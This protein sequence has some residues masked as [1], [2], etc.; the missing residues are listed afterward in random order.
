MANVG[1]TVR[2]SVSEYKYLGLFITPKLIW[3]EAKRS[4]A[5]QARRSIIS[6]KKLRGLL[7]TLIIQKYLNYLIQ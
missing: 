6:M 5:S 3:S 7:V 2:E 1:D 4:L